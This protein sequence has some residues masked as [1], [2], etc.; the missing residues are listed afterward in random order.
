MRA[1]LRVDVI[2]RTTMECLSRY[3]TMALYGDYG[4]VMSCETLM[5]PDTKHFICMPVSHYL[6]QWCRIPASVVF[7]HHI[8]WC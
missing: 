8:V 7:N 2:M 6:Y 4:V 3:E 5:C 1:E